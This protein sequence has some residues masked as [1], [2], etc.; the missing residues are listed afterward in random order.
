MRI[1][2]GHIAVVTGG[3]AG[4][5]RALCV[6]LA[7]RGCHVATCDLNEAKL[8]ET[9]EECR[10]AAPNPGQKFLAL[11]C[12]V[13]DE[14]QCNAFRDAVAEQFRTL[15]I[16][17]L[18]NNAGIGLVCSFV[19]ADRALWERTFNIC[20]GGVYLMCRAFTAM[21]LASSEGAVVNTSSI[22]GML[23]SLGPDMPHT[24]YAA[25]KFAVKGFTESLIID[26]RKHAPHLEAFVVC[27]GFIGT[28][29]VRNRL[30]IFKEASTGSGA[31]SRSEVRAAEAFRSF[32]MP[33]ADAAAV[34]LL[35]V[36]AGRWR[37]LVGDDAEA[38]DVAVRA[39]P[40]G[41]YGLSIDQVFKAGN[42]DYEPGRHTQLA[43]LRAG[44]AAS[45]L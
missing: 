30:A 31:L 7:R 1:K 28:D 27:P 40:V 41:L 34:I 23:A 37:I 17:L 15:H 8:A 32:G 26:F 29:I 38:L 25:A 35:G 11:R 21:L 19:K 14:A 24:A 22:N 20:W 10:A 36:E 5:G 13:S 18:F 6:D 33:A 2:A 3:G 42:P 4:M 12:D 44:R 43:R 39:D 9:L 45:K 16:N